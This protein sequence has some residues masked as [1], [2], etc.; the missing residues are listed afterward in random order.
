MTEKLDPALE[1]IQGVI[2]TLGNEELARLYDTRWFLKE[3]SAARGGLLALKKATEET[4]SKSYIEKVDFL[5]RNHGPAS[6]L[7]GLLRDLNEQLIDDP[8]RQWGSLSELTLRT[9]ECSKIFLVALD[10]NSKPDS[11]KYPV[12]PNGHTQVTL[13]KARLCKVCNDMGEPIPRVQTSS[14]EWLSLE[15]YESS[16]RSGCEGCTVLST[17]L[18]PYKK[19]WDAVPFMRF[20]SAGRG[21]VT[22]IQLAGSRKG[23][24]TLT[25]EIH[26]APGSSC[27]WLIFPQKPIISGNTGSSLAASRVQGW[28]DDCVQNHQHCNSPTPKSLPT[29]IIQIL[30]PR[31]VVLRID[32]NDE[33]AFYVCLSH[34]W[35]QEHM[36][37]TTKDTIVKFQE[38]IPW[39]QL[40]KTFQDAVSFTWSLGYAYIW[41][42]SLC[43]VQDDLGDWRHE[44]SKMHLIYS[45]SILTLAASVGTG[46]SSGCFREVE[47][48]RAWQFWNQEMQTHYGVHLRQTLSHH[49]AAVETKEAEYLPLLDRGW[50]FQERLLSPRVVHF[51]SKELWWECSSSLTCECEEYDRTHS[52]NA[53]IPKT[54]IYIKGH[55]QSHSQSDTVEVDPP[56]NKIVN[57]Y[58]E[59]QFSFQKDIFPALQGLA[60][61]MQRPAGPAYLAGLW[62]DSLLLDLLWVSRGT[63]RPK[64][65]RAP[66]WSWASVVGPITM[67]RRP[68]ALNTVAH[69]VRVET[70]PLGEDPFGELKSGILE[71]KSCCSHARISWGREE[72][73]VPSGK[74][75]LRFGNDHQSIKVHLG[76]RDHGYGLSMVPDYLWG[77][78]NGKMADGLD[79]CIFHMVEEYS[80]HGLGTT[81][82]FLILRRKGLKAEEY[83]RVGLLTCNGTKTGPYDGEGKEGANLLEFQELFETT[84]EEIQITVV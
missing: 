52:N 33:E 6:Y 5:T 17:I 53:T 58:S 72:S 18:Q 36:I 55:H 39:D 28:L 42:D 16:S 66:S 60:K 62:E 40:P 69:I 77:Q 45:N 49:T 70:V 15:T 35:G 79:V 46:P 21:Q 71:I 54:K 4:K 25:L 29:R 31:S 67:Y 84:S 82:R 14:K 57:E 38:A 11:L 78:A 73:A 12:L 24:K 47:D 50:V 75:N 2:Q 41:I 81:G 3:L 34:S 59:K 1:A 44:G 65:W 19:K 22:T 48:A 43:I 32:A 27:P 8:T 51:A 63:R 7:R 37:K 26:V 83:E 23:W 13:G 10:V 64:E 68:K 74:L 20:G 76:S 56:W 30:G 9:R 80:D 61:R